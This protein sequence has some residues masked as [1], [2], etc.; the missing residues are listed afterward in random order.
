MEIWKDSFS[1][2]SLLIDSLRG[3][4]D[5][6]SKKAADFALMTYIINLKLNADDRDEIL[7]LL[8]DKYKISNIK[9]MPEIL[10]M[11][12]LYFFQK[13]LGPTAGIVR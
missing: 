3:Q 11:V 7:N 10:G 12:K 2:V 1:S 4:S 6:F 8:D 5:P 13:Q 9:K